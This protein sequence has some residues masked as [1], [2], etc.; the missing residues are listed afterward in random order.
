MDLTER[1]GQGTQ[2]EGEAAK[3]RIDSCTRVTNPHIW[4]TSWTWSHEMKIISTGETEAG[5]S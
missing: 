3:S 4:Q 5:G 2:W 1:M